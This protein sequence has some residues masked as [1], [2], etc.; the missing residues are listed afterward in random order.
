MR[1]AQYSILL[2]A[3]V[4]IGVLHFVTPG[5]YLF[6]HDTYRRLSYFPIVLGGL[7][8]GLWGGVS[9]AVLSSIAFI[10]HLLLF[11]GHAPQSYLS[12]LTEILLYVSA[13]AV[14][15]L[16]AGREKRLREK[17]RQISEKLEKS[18]ESLH[19]QTAQLIEAEE[20]LAEV[21]KL[22]A[23]GQMSASL[24]H[25]IK[26]PLGSIKGTAEILLD[27][28]PEGHPKREFVDILL[29]ETGRLNKTV[30]NVLQFSRR[31]PGHEE[32]RE[33]FADVVAR[34]RALLGKQFRE[35]QITLTILG[36]E[37]AAEFSV[38]SGKMT[39]VLLN[40]LLNAYDAVGAGGEITL[41]VNPAEGGYSIT[42][43]DN[44]P[45]IPAN[46]RE[47]IFE[48]FVSEK[49]GGTGLGLVISKKII[50]SFGGTIS[51]A[52]AKGHGACFSIFLPGA[53]GKDEIVQLTTG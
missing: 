44:G 45:G 15:G 22:S 26:N 21:Q 36:Q 48:P 1:K 8:F 23:L 53:N 17:Y 37:Y 39:Q 24:A 12:E 20:H 4:L 16:M 38:V 30:E 46:V 11:A 40:L 27:D 18:Y 10:P 52:E 6:F 51:L 5:Q 3:V 33:P 32:M 28:F 47:R 34:I 2:A 13:G 9:L 49:E 14:T 50:E 25:E 31:K 19:E 43:C 29:K 41:A 35:K 42:I 7:W